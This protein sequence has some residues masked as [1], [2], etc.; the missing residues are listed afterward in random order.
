MKILIIRTLQSDLLIRLIKKCREQFVDCRFYILTHADQENLQPII[1]QFTKVYEYRAHGNFCLFRL[2]GGLRREIRRE[3]FD[4]LIIPKKMDRLIG[5]ENVL[6]LAG[7]LNVKKWMHCGIRGDLFRISKWRLLPIFIG[8]LIA[9]LFALI[10]F[11]VLILLVIFFFAVN[12][13]K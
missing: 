2:D 11:V 8:K 1:E 13:K 6:V 12:K 10:I 3:K 4:L 5:F 9:A 7:A